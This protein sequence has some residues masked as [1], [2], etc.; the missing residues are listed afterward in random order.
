MNDVISESPWSTAEIANLSWE[1]PAGSF[2]ILR[3]WA[4]EQTCSI[5]PYEGTYDQE[6]GL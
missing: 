5:R 3:T 6:A 1:K 4:T 2:E